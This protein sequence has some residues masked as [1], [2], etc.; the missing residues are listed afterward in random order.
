MT[1]CR[2]KKR[3]QGYTSP[4]MLSLSDKETSKLSRDEIVAVISLVN[5]IWPNKEKTVDQMVEDYHDSYRRY[6]A[7]YPGTARLSV[8]HLAWEDGR[9][10]GHAS[11]FERCVISEGLETPVMALS[12]VCVAP[13]CR[14]K[15]IGAELVRQA[16]QRIRSGE[17]P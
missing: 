10:V 11:S 6:W 7:Q 9:L 3:A 12:G 8:R 5:S 4:A 13:D 17:F 1:R 14:G 15:G 16:F 2:A